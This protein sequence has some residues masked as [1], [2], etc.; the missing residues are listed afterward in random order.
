MGMTRASL[1]GS[2]HHCPDSSAQ[3]TGPSSCSG[4]VRRPASSARA[5]HFHSRSPSHVL[6]TPEL[7]YPTLNWVPRS[8]GVVEVDTS[9]TEPHGQRPSGSKARRKRTRTTRA[10]QRCKRSQSALAT[11]PRDGRSVCQ[12]DSTGVAESP[13]RSSPANRTISD[14]ACISTWAALRR[15][16]CRGN[17]WCVVTW[18]A[19]RCGTGWP[20]PGQ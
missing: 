16:N 19:N 14:V 17:A 6:A 11:G 7:A 12:A 10:S 18:R 2:P 4:R 20:L 5:A 1:S 13:A 9:R 8:Q 15:E 3:S